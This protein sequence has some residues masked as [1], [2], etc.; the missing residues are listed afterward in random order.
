MYVPWIGLF[1]ELTVEVFTLAVDVTSSLPCVLVC[2]L[3]KVTVPGFNTDPYVELEE[4]IA[5]PKRV[6]LLTL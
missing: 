6:S 1:D 5:V 2:I 3:V 4:S